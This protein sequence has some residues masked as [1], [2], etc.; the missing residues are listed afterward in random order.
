M[1]A[2][3]VRISVCHPTPQICKKSYTR[4]D[5]L[6]RHIKA[7]QSKTMM[8]MNRRLNRVTSISL[9]DMMPLDISIVINVGKYLFGTRES[10]ER[11]IMQK[12]R[13]KQNQ[14]LFEQF[15]CM[16]GVRVFPK[17]ET[18]DNHI[19][20]MHQM[21]QKDLEQRTSTITFNQPFTIT[22]AGRTRSGKTTG[23]KLDGN[24]FLNFGFFG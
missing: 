22:V 18:L 12:E 16:Y 14:S 13:S 20:K 19:H 23:V 9:K 8:T 15:K 11:H 10:L 6:K 7:R 4:H 17:Q 1:N 2:L 5:A 24:A 21:R 3:N